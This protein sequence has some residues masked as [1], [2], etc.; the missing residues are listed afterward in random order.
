MKPRSLLSATLLLAAQV[1]AAELVPQAEAMQLLQKVSQA[2]KLLNYSGVYWYQHG[3]SQETFRLLHL[4]DQ[5]E[6]EKRE[7][8]DGAQREFIRHND[9]VT[10]YLPDAK[11]FQLDRRATNKLFPSLLPAD[12]QNLL[13]NYSVK[14]LG[15]ERV[16]GFDS[17]VIQLEPKDKL[18]HAHKLWLEKQSHLLLKVAMLH[19]E[20]REAVEQFSFTQLQIG[21]SIDRKLLRPLLSARTAQEGK[22]SDAPDGLSESG[23][24]LR[25]VPVGFKLVKESQRQLPGKAKPVAHYLYSDGLATVSV[26]VEP[27]D[28]GVAPMPV[29][30]DVS[31]SA[32][33]AGNLN[34][35][36]LGEVPEQTVQQFSQAVFVR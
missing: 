15:A 5:G 8:L 32:R 22:G 25:N 27:A 34:I 23:W 30:R 21:G 9:Q 33:Q 4:A 36:V 19:Q 2:A 16:A 1:S 17:D 11:P 24:G 7:A 28:N 3:D 12:P 31:V 13:N 35:T 10:C 6:A 26:F 14:R 18:R 29:Q 20:R